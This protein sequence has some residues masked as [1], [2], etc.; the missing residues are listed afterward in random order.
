MHSLSDVMY[1]ACNSTFRFSG[2][3][4]PLA[5]SKSSLRAQNFF[6]SWFRDEPQEEKHSQWCDHLPHTFS[7]Q[8]VE[9]RGKKKPPKILQ[10]E[11]E[12]AE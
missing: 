9:L 2:P 1:L 6:F 5:Y 10:L 7:C 3:S 12:I 4:R 11:T 8:P